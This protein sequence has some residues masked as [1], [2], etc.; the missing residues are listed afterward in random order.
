MRRVQSLAEMYC[1]N[2]LA[3]QPGGTLID[4]GANIG[5]LGIWARSRGLGYVPFE[6][7]PLEAFCCDLNNFGGSSRT[8]R[9]ALWKETATLPF[10]SKPDSADSSLIAPRGDWRRT[11]VEAVTLDS[12]L[13]LTRLARASGTVIFKVEAEG[14]EPEVLEG[15]VTTL[16][17]VDWVAIDCGPERGEHLAHTF[18]ETNTFMQDHGF[19][20]HRARFDRIIALYSNTKRHSS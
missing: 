3:I 15:S 1:L 20:L 4:C 8:Q 12:T 10:Y 14:V 16:C 9:Q 18:V 6:P 19:R 13:D 5:E 17:E 2:D 11:E 7:E